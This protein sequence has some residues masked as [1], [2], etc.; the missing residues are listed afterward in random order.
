MWRWVAI[1]NEVGGE[2]ALKMKGVDCGREME[3]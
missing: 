3:G 2:A 1:G